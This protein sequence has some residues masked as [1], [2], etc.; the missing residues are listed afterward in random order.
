MPDRD[1]KKP[2]SDLMGWKRL[3][4]QKSYEVKGLFTLEEEPLR[5]GS[6]VDTD[7]FEVSFDVGPV[8]EDWSFQFRARFAAHDTVLDDPFWQNRQIVRVD[9]V[10]RFLIWRMIYGD[11]IECFGLT[12]DAMI[13]K[14]SAK[15]EWEYADD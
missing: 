8:N 3:V 9:R 15:Y 12:T 13:K 4:D 6:F 11:V 1:A 5:D 2:L 7:Y 10:S 14:L